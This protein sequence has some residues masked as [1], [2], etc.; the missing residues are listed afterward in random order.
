MARA[1]GTRKGEMRGF[2]TRA[3]TG[4]IIRIALRVDD[5]VG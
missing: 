2:S 4:R 1:L 3:A 5:I